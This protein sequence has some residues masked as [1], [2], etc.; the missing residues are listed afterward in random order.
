MPPHPA[1]ARARRRG[2]H[3]P[4]HTPARSWQLHPQP[5]LN[6]RWNPVDGPTEEARVSCALHD[7]RGARQAL[8]RRLLDKGAMDLQCPD[9]HRMAVAHGLWGAGRRKDEL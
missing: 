4:V 8:A 5:W 9:L 6:L 3:T 7:A 1:H 2:S